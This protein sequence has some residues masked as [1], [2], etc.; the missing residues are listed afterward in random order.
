MWLRKT[1]LIKR[2]YLKNE[3]KNSFDFKTL[4]ESAISFKDIEKLQLFEVG[5][6]QLPHLLRYEDRNS[7][8]HSIETRLPFLDYRVVEFSL[9][10]NPN[11][12]IK[13]G[14]TKFILRKAVEDILPDSIAWRKDKKGFEAPEKTWLTETIEMMKFQI[15]ESK[16]LLELIDVER[17][18]KDFDKL[19]FRRRWVYFIIAAW[20]KRFNVV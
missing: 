19:P 15:K 3:I 20:E 11:Y 10:M 5:T 12:K 6:L 13:D 9:S 2:S 17:L 8:R 4:Q 16:L 1:R 18:I 7:M 14:W